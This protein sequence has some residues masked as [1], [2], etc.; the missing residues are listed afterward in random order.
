MSDSAPPT[1][2]VTTMSETPEALVRRFF[3]EWEDPR[4]DRLASFFH[5]DARW[6][7]G[8]Q[9][10]R[11]G[12]AA[13][14][15]ELTGQL[16]AV[17][18]AVVEVRTLLADASTVMVEQISH[19]TIRGKTVSSVVMAVFEFDDGGRVLQWRETYD[20]KSAVDQIEAA[21]ASR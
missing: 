2:E 19:S 10:V 14:V 21:V 16:T 11:E 7:D 5:D 17:G 3:T 4:P 6:H 1:V 13:I 9:G 20:L 15:A 18:G 12:A 8:P